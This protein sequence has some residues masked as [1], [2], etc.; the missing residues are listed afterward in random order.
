MAIVANYEKFCK[1]CS[2]EF[3]HWLSCQD[4]DDKELC[5]FILEE[6]GEPYKSH[7]YD[8]W[9]LDIP[10]QKESI[11]KYLQVLCVNLVWSLGYRCIDEFK[12][13]KNTVIIFLVGVL[14]TIDSSPTIT[15]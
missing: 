1:F 3:D 15:R 6:H 13:K 11:F 7:N 8:T 2:D 10:D 12:G 9:W 5:E 4:E 14:A